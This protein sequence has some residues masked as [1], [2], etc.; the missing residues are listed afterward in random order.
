[1]IATSLLVAACLTLQV[2]SP[3]VAVPTP[4]LEQQVR[5]LVQQLDDRDRLVRDAAEKEL[6]RLGAEVLALLP[7]IDNRTPAEVKERL[8]RVRR[9]LEQ[10]AVELAVEASRVTLRGPLSLIEILTQ[11]G[12]Q[13]GN[14]VVDYRDRFNQ[15]AE[16]RR[17]DLALQDEPFW[18]ALDRI[19]DQ[20]GL[21]VYTYVGQPHTI[22]VVAAR[23]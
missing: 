8:T 4:T 20:A 23:R 3:A 21:T 16:D 7:P 22:G 6:V 12:Q 15:P 9:T 11:L 13:T 18:P 19:L 17:V 14:Q 10:A 2:E 1:M 5:Q